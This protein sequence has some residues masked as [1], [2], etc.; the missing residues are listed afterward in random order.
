[1]NLN[2]KDQDPVVSTENVNYLWLV[3]KLQIRWTCFALSIILKTISKDSLN[4]PLI[5]IFNEPSFKDILFL[6]KTKLK[7]TG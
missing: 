1:M 4:L 5:S 6:V 3:C 2:S 7:H